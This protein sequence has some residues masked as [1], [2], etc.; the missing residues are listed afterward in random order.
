MKP[1]EATFCG[2]IPLV[3]AEMSFIDGFTAEAGPKKKPFG[4]ASP[5]ALREAVLKGSLSSLACPY[6]PNVFHYWTSEFNA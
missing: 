4:I 5:E 2:F 6:G 1:V 3:E